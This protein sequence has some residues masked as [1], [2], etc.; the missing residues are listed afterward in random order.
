VWWRVSGARSWYYGDQRLVGHAGWLNAAR[1]FDAA[2]V[3][4]RTPNAQVDVFAAS[5]VRILD[6]AFDKSGNGNRFAGAYVTTGKVLPNAT[7][8]PYVFWRRD[9]N[10]RGE[11]GTLGSLKQITS[12]ARAAGRLPARLDYNVEM[13]LQTGSLAA[14]EVRAWAGHWQLRASLPGRMAPHITGEY[15]FASGDSNPA[16]GTRGTFDQLYATAHDKYGLADQ[17]G[18]RNIHDV[19]FGFDVSPF[20]AT[21]VTVN[22][23]SYWLAESRDALYAASGAVLARIATGAASTKVGQEIDLQIARPISPQLALAAGYSHLFAGPF[24]KQATPGRSYS[25]PFVMLT[26]V[27]LA[28]K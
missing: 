18:W 24:L 4:F 21:P 2:R 9:G 23:H 13:D 7:L 19:R 5:V 20:K 6:G 17:V 12:G 25:G 26:Y 28:E 3:T 8:E 1:T 10:L 14:D 11:T 16:D 27:F 22:Y 15:N